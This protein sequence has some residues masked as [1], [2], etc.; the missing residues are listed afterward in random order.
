[1]A[2]EAADKADAQSAFLQRLPEHL[3]HEIFDFFTVQTEWGTKVK[4]GK[5]GLK[6]GDL[7]VGSYGVVKDVSDNRSLR[8]RGAL[9]R[10]GQVTAN[11]GYYIVNKTD[12]WSDNA[13][14]LYEEAIQ[15]RWAPATDI[16]WTTIRPLPEDIEL[17]ICQVCTTLCSISSALGTAVGKHLQDMSYEF[18]EIK[19]FL[20]TECYD[21]ARHVDA[22][23]KRALY[24][25]GGLLVP[26]SFAYKTMLEE[27]DW[28]GATTEIHMV[29]ESFLRT[30]LEAC[31]F[32]APHMAEKTLF[33]LAAQDLTRHITFGMGH[34]RY[35]LSVEPHRADELTNY[36][37]SGERFILTEYFGDQTWEA[38]AILL[39]GGLANY[40]R[41]CSMVES[42]KRKMVRDYVTRLETIGLH[43]YAHPSGR[44][45]GI[46]YGL[47]KLME[48]AN[49]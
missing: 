30:M 28:V 32:A 23:R 6:L 4:P 36:L 31:E 3:R 26:P 38:L 12:L 8:A 41:G 21:H 24:N 7:N 1:M 19:C 48:D 45:R 34:I 14:A 5:A 16:A 46:R 22:F 9:M 13:A 17:S 33:G 18:H 2:D 37:L 15:R 35:L 43:A 40:E 42:L 47:K 49:A 27:R 11:Q 20:A 29:V 39:G 25:G 10:P 44:M